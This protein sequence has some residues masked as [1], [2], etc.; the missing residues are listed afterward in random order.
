MAK[1]SSDNTKPR[2]KR[3][4]E[5]GTLIGVRLQSDHLG[6]LDAWISEQNEPFTRPEAIRRLV[7]QALGSSSKKK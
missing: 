2:W 4:A 7:E 6:A 1:T 3:S 5:R